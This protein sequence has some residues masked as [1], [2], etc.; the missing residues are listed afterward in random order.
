MCESTLPNFDKLI[1]LVVA[2]SLMKKP[3]LIQLAIDDDGSFPD[4][5]TRRSKQQLQP[6]LPTL[7]SQKKYYLAYG[8]AKDLL[9]GSVGLAEALRQWQLLSLSPDLTD[10]VVDWQAKLN[11]YWLSR[12]G[13]VLTLSE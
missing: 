3:S 9:T 4:W 11:I 5:A 13:S 1:S 12:T 6:L 7:T 2:E 10:F 8:V